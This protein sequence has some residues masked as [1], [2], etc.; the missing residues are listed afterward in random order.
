MKI[1]VKE[2]DFKVTHISKSQYPIDKLNDSIKE[3]NNLAEIVYL[4]GSY[5]QC[6]D[7]T[8]FPKNFQ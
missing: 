5:T 7:I 3:R 8:N 1:L 6:S 4:A 2:F